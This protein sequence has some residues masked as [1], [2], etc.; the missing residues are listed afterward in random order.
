MPSSDRREPEVAAGGP[1]SSGSSVH[2]P[3]RRLINFLCNSILPAIVKVAQR[4]SRHPF[5]SQERKK[6]GRET[7]E[8]FRHCRIADLIKSRSA[9]FRLPFEKPAESDRP[10]GVGQGVERIPFF[11]VISAASLSRTSSKA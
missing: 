8:N 5:V 11:E 2:G 4:C 10:K 9:K 6:G 3:A 7:K 1:P